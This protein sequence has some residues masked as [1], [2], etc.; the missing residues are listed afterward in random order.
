MLNNKMDEYL[1]YND[2]EE[3]ISRNY[4]IFMEERFSYKTTNETNDNN[5][6]LSKNTFGSSSSSSINTQQTSSLSTIDPLIIKAKLYILEILEV[7]I[8]TVFLNL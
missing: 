4:L 2:E 1:L 6:S 3:L 7:Y 8:L 5:N